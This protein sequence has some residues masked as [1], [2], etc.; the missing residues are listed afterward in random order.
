MRHLIIALAIGTTLF[1]SDAKAQQIKD[2]T[3]LKPPV[4]AEFLAGNNR[5]FSQLIV[6]KPITEDQKIGFVNIVSFAASYKNDFTK[7]EYLNISALYYKLTKRISIKTGISLNTAEGLKP[8]AGLQYM[9]ANKSVS[10]VYF[11]AYYY[12]HNHKIFNLL[13]LEYRPKIENNWSGYS[14]L[15]ANY[16]YDI[17]HKKHFR[18]YLYLRLGA[19]YKNIT[20][21]AGAN[22]DRYGAKKIF[23]EN[24]GAFLNLK[25]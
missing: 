25:L 10:I 3:K 4:T 18:S 9:Y 21:G 11:P 17:E 5:L 2:T 7:N 14:R 6:N 24:Y 1:A 19:T 16:Q 12:L 23:R 22:L 15:Q 8:L 20:F 13:F